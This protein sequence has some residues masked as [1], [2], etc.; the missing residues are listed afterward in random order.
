MNDGIL[1]ES[2]TPEQIFEHPQEARTQ[3]FLKR[4]LSRV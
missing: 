1:A 4:Y 3:E 2:G